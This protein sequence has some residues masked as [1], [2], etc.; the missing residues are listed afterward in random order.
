MFLHLTIFQKRYPLYKYGVV[1]S[2]TLGVAVFTLYHPST[3]SK[4]SKAG[5]AGSSMYGL[6]LL[7]INLL[8]DGLTNT[9]QDHVFST[10]QRYGSFKGPQMMVA[11]NLISTVMTAAYL[12]LTPHL[13]TLPLSSPASSN[14]LSNAISFLS[15]HPSALYDVLGFAA[16]GAIGQI[17]IYMTLNRF[18]SILLVT[19]TVTRKMLSMLLS[20]VWF[21]KSLTHGQWLGVALVFGGV[22]VEGWIQRREKLAKEKAKP[23]KQ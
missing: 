1:A 22:G 8:F 12:L 16:C 14:E 2:V 20:V 7:G 3:A 15:R 11:Q 9:V 18:G 21:G 19:V 17:F 4:N 5:P 13:P 23:K 6:A 10:P